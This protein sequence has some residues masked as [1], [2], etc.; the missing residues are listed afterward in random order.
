MP[1]TG[2]S[3]C[4]PIHWHYREDLRDRDRVSTCIQDPTRMLLGSGHGPP[5]LWRFCHIRTW[6]W[7]PVCG[8]FCHVLRHVLVHGKWMRPC[9]L[10]KRLSSIYPQKTFLSMKGP[11]SHIRFYSF[12]Y[13]SQVQNMNPFSMIN[14]HA[15]IML[16]QC[17][18]LKG[19]WF[20]R[21]YRCLWVKL[22]LFNTYS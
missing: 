11:K 2:S 18:Y 21:L 12:C 3:S 7:A 5:S 1:W 20:P 22:S 8:V 19:L 9:F 6:T 10:T 16:A 15:C 14:F 13:I 17:L 4:V